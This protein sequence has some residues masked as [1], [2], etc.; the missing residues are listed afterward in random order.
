MNKI[1]IFLS[2]PQVLFREGIHFILS[3]EEDFEVTGEATNNE[4]A[5]VHIEANPPH[6]TILNIEDKKLSGPEIVRRLKRRFPSLSAILTIE[7][8]DEKKLFEAIESGTS[9][10]LTK[11]T[12]P[13]NLLDTVT[14]VSQGSIPIIEELLTPA[15]AARTLAEFEETNSLNY[16]MD[17]LMAGLTV[18]EMQI[19]N[20]IATGIGIEQ[21]ASSV[22]MDEDTIRSCLK[23]VLNKLVTN[24]QT[25]AVIS[26]IQRGL[27]SM[28]GG[29]SRLKGLTEEYLTRE[30]FDKFKD[31]LAK[32]L[33]NVVGEVV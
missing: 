5:L 20:G 7:K 2:D 13:E 25:R 10:C 12:N 17:N 9:A 14:A 19:L 3:G 27:P 24:D 11:D 32:R 30:E 28:L 22:N 15:I 21:V 6:I 23:L 8:R 18:P 4:E 26:T 29:S 1:K 16:G 33:R 31:T